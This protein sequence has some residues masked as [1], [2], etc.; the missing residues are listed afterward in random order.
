MDNVKARFEL[1]ESGFWNARGTS[2]GHS[3]AITYAK[4]IRVTRSRFVEA[5]GALWDD[6]E[7]SETAH[8]TVEY[9]ISK[10]AD[11]ALKRARRA[12]SIA[13]EAQRESERCSRDVARLLTEAGM[14]VDDASTLLDL[15]PSSFRRLLR[16]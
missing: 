4:S 6:V 14:G 9:V 8:L 7:R 2:P 3:A 5:L 12:R 1:D 16:D 13:E 15:S 10:K 11:A